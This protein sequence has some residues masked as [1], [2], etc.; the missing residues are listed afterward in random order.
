MK[1][2]IPHL[3]S[4][5]AD[6]L[7]GPEAQYRMAHAVRGTFPNNSESARIACVLLAL[8]PKAG[9]WHMVLIQRV[10]SNPNDRHGGQISFPGGGYEEQDANLEAGALREA[11]EE[12]GIIPQDVQVLGR[13]TELFIPVSNFMVHPFIG[14]LDYAPNFVPQ[15]SEVQ[16]IIEV[17]LATLRNPTTRQITQIR[18]SEKV[19]LKNV[20]YFDVQGH[21]VWGATAMMLNEF[22]DLL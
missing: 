11:H 6:P 13:L 20:P 17:P 10:S 4:K 18:I 15:I 22:L 1:N 16:K 2:L 5:L 8:Y 12:V 3:Q 9:D 7:P 14:H 19:T 21:V